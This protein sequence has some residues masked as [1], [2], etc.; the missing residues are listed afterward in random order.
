MVVS[1]FL[2]FLI[3]LY[4]IVLTFDTF[5]LVANNSQKYRQLVD[6][7]NKSKYCGRIIAF[8]Q[9]IKIKSKLKMNY[10]TSRNS[11]LYRDICTKFEDRIYTWNQNSK[12]ENLNNYNYVF[13]IKLMENENDYTFFNRLFSNA[14]WSNRF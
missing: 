9:N 14:N 6:A 3:I 13:R 10:H 1:S 12:Q 11:F 7:R 4:S 2:S 5:Y 8:D